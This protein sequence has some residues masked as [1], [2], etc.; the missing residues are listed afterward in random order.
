MAQSNLIVGTD[1]GVS[2]FSVTAPAGKAQRFDVHDDHPILAFLVPQEVPV[3]VGNQ[4]TV[5]VSHFGTGNVI[6]Y[7][8]NTTMA[9]LQAVPTITSRASTIVTRGMMWGVSGEFRNLVDPSSGI[10]P[11]LQDM[12]AEG[13]LDD[14]AQGSAVGAAMLA[15]SFTTVTTDSGSTAQ[16]STVDTIALTLRQTFASER[17]IAIYS[18][19]GLKDLRDDVTTSGAGWTISQASNKVIEDLI[20]R[21]NS[22]LAANRYR[23]SYDNIDFYTT[24]KEAG[25]YQTGGNSYGII[26]VPPR[27]EDQVS[28]GGQKMLGPIACAGRKDP[29]GGMKDAE[30]VDSYGPIGIY[31]FKRDITGE[32]AEVWCYLV[33]YNNWLSHVTAA[34]VPARAHLYSTT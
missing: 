26:M 24:P 7:A 6:A 1:T 13:L 3:G 9:A 2:G 19:K 23:F 33:C 8:E 5:S 20:V 27:G 34:S 18:P 10:L 16:M 4:R 29:T 25:L 17:L 11:L 22:G 32:N 31:K 15:S 30:L 12:T 21:Q 28:Y 14:I